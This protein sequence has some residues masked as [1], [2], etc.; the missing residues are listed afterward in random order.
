PFA[1]PGRPAARG[2]RRP[3]ARDG[4]R[5]P[6]ARG[7]R[8]AQG[9]V[10]LDR[11]SHGGAARADGRGNRARLLRPD[12]GLCGRRIDRQPRPRG[13]G[14]NERPMTMSGGF[15][16]LVG[17]GPGD[18]DLL[19]LRAVDRLRSADLV[20]HDGLVPAAVLALAGAAECVSVARRVG[21]KRLSQQDVCGLMVAAARIGQR[22]V[23]LKSGD[24]FVFGRAGA[25]VHALIEAGI[26]FEVV[27]GLS[28][29]IAAPTLAGIPVTH[30]GVS[31]G[32]LVVSGH[33]PEAWAPL[34]GAI[35]PGAATVVVLMGKRTRG[36]IAAF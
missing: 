36:D 35:P 5:G 33:A 9:R 24:P 10:A 30:G 34:L 25:E 15:V 17:A 1:G 28:T 3:A 2:H 18:P 11:C 23:R 21:E 27:P 26:P 13:A 16:S 19:T 22:V 4:G 31:S 7:G 14:G 12:A 20:L 29:A 32:L 8:R 6:L